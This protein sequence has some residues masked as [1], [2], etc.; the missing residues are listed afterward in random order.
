L[1]QIRCH[2]NG[3]GNN[4]AGDRQTD[5]PLA[6]QERFELIVQ[7]STA[8]TPAYVLTVAEG[9]PKMKRSDGSGQSGCR[10]MRGSPNVA[11]GSASFI[12]VSCRNETMQRFAGEVRAL[13]PSYLD[14]PVVD[15]TGLTDSWDFDLKWTP[16]DHLKRAGANAIPIFEAMRDQ[17]GIKLTLATAP[18]HV[19]TVESVNE[20]PTLNLPD[21]AKRLPPLPPAQLEVAV[22]RPAKPGEEVQGG[23]GGDRIDVHAFTL[24]QLID[25]AWNLGSDDSETP[26]C[27]T[28][29]A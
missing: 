4:S 1:G 27:C 25:F 11:P 28:Q 5:A 6:A 7:D 16:R 12:E 14:Q 29:S 21:I 9:K 19:L 23:T 17:L 15:S 24:E 20:N 18:T 8:Q 10:S 3:S 2:R 22:I 13:A 26:P